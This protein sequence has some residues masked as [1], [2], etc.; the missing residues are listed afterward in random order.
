VGRLVSYPGETG[1]RGK[2]REIAAALQ[3]QFG[4]LVSFSDPTHGRNA[5]VKVQCA[6]E[7]S[8]DI[9]SVG[10]SVSWSV[11]RSVG[12]SVG[13]SVTL[14][15]RETGERDRRQ[16]KAKRV[17]GILWERKGITYKKVSM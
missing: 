7:R 5:S 8:V 17:K 6:P 14:A 1:D 2:R 11:G 15:R 10:R 16:G 13:R 3:Q 9:R 4:V 12:G